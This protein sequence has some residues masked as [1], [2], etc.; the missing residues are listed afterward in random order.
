MVRDLFEPI[1][2]Q[3]KTGDCKHSLSTLFQSDEQSDLLDLV[4]AQIERSDVGSR[5]EQLVDNS[6][7]SIVAKFV[8]RKV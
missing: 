4:V 8:V 5:V 3:C 2:I 1:A 6:T 7:T